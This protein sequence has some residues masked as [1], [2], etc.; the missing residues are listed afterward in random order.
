VEQGGIAITRCPFVLYASRARPVR[1]LFNHEDT[2]ATKTTEPNNYLRV[3]RVLR[4][5]SERA[6]RLPPHPAPGELQRQPAQ[7]HIPGA[8][9]PLIPGELPTAERHRPK[10]QIAPGFPPILKRAPD[11]PFLEQAGRASRRNPFQLHQPPQ[12]TGRRRRRH[13]GVLRL[14]EDSELRRDHGEA[15]LGPG[16]TR[17]HRRRQDRSRPVGHRR[18]P[19]ADPALRQAPAPG[20][21]PAAHSIHQAGLFLFQLPPLPTA[22]THAFGFDTR[23]PHLPPDV[24][25]ALADAHQHHDQFLGVDPI[26]LRAPRPSIHLD[27]RRVHHA[28]A[29]ADHDERAMNP[30]SIAARFI[31]THHTGRCGQVQA[32]ARPRQQPRHRAQVSRRHRLNP[33]RHPEP[34]CHRQLPLFGAELESHI[35]RRL[36]YTHSRSADRSHHSL[37]SVFTHPIRSLLAAARAHSLFVIDKRLDGCGSI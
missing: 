29:Q 21:D 17:L 18:P 24:P 22:M 32:R 31:A 16:E 35:Q 33:R 25:L 36:G 27:A 20:G 13:R 4:D 11:E 28:I 6:R 8:I 5:F 12:R 15:R 7:A 1:H 30:E 2:K 10:A 23:H 19:V 37:L 14:I 3:L 34:R 26:G 9:N